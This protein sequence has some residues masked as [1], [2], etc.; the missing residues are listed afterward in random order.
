MEKREKIARAIHEGWKVRMDEKAKK[1][2]SRFRGRSLCWEEL[3]EEA[4]QDFLTDADS[5]IKAIEEDK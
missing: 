1:I 3:D 2:D 4:Q 5:A